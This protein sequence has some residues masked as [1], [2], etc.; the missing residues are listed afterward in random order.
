MKK[1][2]LRDLSHPFEGEMLKDML[3]GIDIK[4]WVADEN[5]P[6]NMETYLGIKKEKTY[7]FVNEEDFQ[8]AD[9][10]LSA[11]IKEEM[12]VEGVLPPVRFPYWIIIGF[13]MMI[14]IGFLAQEI[15]S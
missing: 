10:F 8:A 9:S 11:Q 3:K 13:T 14:L 12:P 5:G 7:I 15:W 6:Q 4:S 2:I 1:V